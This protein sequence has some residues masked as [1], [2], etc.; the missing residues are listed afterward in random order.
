MTLQSHLET[1]CT[2]VCRAWEIERK[3]GVKLGFTDH[4]L[5]LTF[6]GIEFRPSNG[7]TSRAI[8]Q[9]T[10]LAVDNTEALG[11]LSDA[12]ITETDIRVGLYDGAR[13]RAWRVNW[14]NVVERAMVFQGS[15]GEVERSGKAFRAELRGLSDTLGQ[16]RGRVFQA[17]CSATFGDD[18]C[19]IDSLATE[20]A[21][22]ATVQSLEDGVRIVVDLSGYEPSWFRHGR[23]TV[24]SGS[25]AGVVRVIKRD[26]VVGSARRLEVWEQIDGLA[27]GDLIQIEAGCDKCASTCREKFD[28]FVNFRGFPDIPGEDWLMSYPVA[29]GTNDGGS[30]S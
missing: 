10:G 2:T 22:V 19:G 7:F 24:T 30:L 26:D 18:Q 16:V 14:Q 20:F 23:L 6:D 9:V 15:L 3:D 27:T 28:N 25:A 12:A 1:G 13:V 29:T 8:E 11:A 21:R 17:P 5:S 4:D